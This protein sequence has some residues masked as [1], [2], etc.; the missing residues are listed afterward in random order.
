[1]TDTTTRR[2]WSERF[3]KIRSDPQFQELLRKLPQEEQDKVQEVL[4]ELVSRVEAQ[5]LNPLGIALQGLR[6]KRSR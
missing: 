2:Q 6:S 4:Q 3:E 5:V 1:M